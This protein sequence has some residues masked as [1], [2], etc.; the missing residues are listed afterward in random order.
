MSAKI[1]STPSE[2]GPMIWNIIHTASLRIGK[3][4][5][6]DKNETRLFIALIKSLPY[7]LPCKV[8]QVHAGE[9]LRNAESNKRISK[10]ISLSGDTLKA[11]IVHFFW[12][13]HN[14]VNKV[15]DTP[16]GFYELE[17]LITKY[18]SDELRKQTKEDL[19]ILLRTISTASHQGVIT[20][21]ETRKIRIIL[22][23]LVK[24]ASIGW[25]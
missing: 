18:S 4:A 15:K 6:T 17:S 16:T 14:N 11:E 3:N 19:Q 12:D 2:W 20:A 25:L 13:F 10:W 7:S 9:Y 5:V 21:E 23:Q 22:Q 8:C 1:A 24:L